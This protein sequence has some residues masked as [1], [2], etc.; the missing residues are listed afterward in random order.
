VF[1]TG[2]GSTVGSYTLYRLKRAGKAPIAIVNE[3]CETI[4]AV[5]C[6]IAE[7]PCVDQVPINELRTG[8]LVKVDGDQ[9]VVTLLAE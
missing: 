8:Q 7:I 6:I 2:K 9:G 5:G 1:P 3:E 4:T